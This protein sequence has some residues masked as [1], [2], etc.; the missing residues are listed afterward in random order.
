MSDYG[1]DSSKAEEGKHTV[2]VAM[3]ILDPGNK[4]S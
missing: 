1:E 3:S 4:F 2:T